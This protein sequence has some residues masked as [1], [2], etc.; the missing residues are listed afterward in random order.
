MRGGQSVLGLGDLIYV[1]T[2]PRRDPRDGRAIG[3]RRMALV[4]VSGFERGDASVRLVQD[5]GRPED[6]H[7]GPAADARAAAAGEP[8]AAEPAKRGRGR[9]PGSKS[10]PK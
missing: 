3:E 4:M 6:G 8:G 9:P 2:R 5:F 1:S 10:K 7:G